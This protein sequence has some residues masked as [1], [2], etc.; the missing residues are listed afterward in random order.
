MEQAIISAVADADGHIRTVRLTVHDRSQCDNR[1]LPCVIHN[2]SRHIMSAWPLAWR[3]DVSLMERIC[4]HG[5]GH[6][7]P[8]HLAYVNSGDREVIVRHGCDG[9]CP[10]DSGIGCTFLARNPM[11]FNEEDTNDSDA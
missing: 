8:D 1:V 10:Y 3:D 7:D 11:R 4:E 5:V 2:P 9:C 6:P